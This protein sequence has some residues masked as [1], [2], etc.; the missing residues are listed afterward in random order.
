[1]IKTIGQDV[2]LY[3][4]LVHQYDKYKSEVKP[5]VYFLGLA[6]EVSELAGG[7]KDFNGYAD[8]ETRAIQKENKIIGEIGDVFWYWFALAKELKF[9]YYEMW[10]I[11]LTNMKHTKPHNDEILYVVESSGRVIEHLKKSIRD[12]NG[13]IT[14]ERK[15]K[16]R[17]K[18][19]ETLDYLL[20]FAKSVNID[21]Y[22]IMQRN[23]DKLYARNE[24]GTISGE[25]DGITKSER[26]S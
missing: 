21:P 14:S 9:N 13:E 23:Y 5:T 25:G 7:I 24:E 19:L 6:G 2:E 26:T 20:L 17:E 15:E 10:N 3:V 12:D 8:S 22:H 11:A 4:R 1:M 16:I 18:M